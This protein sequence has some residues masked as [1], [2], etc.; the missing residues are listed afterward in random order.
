MNRGPKNGGKA[1]KKSSNKDPIPA[2]RRKKSPYEPELRGLGH[3]ISPLP[4]QGQAL[5]RNAAACPE[6]TALGSW[7]RG[8]S[9]AG[10]EDSALLHRP[11]CPRKPEE[12]GRDSEPQVLLQIL[13]LARDQEV[14]LSRLLSKDPVSTEDLEKVAQ[15]RAGLLGHYERVILSDVG[16]SE[17]QNVSQALWKNAFHQVIERLGQ[18]LRHPKT[19]NPEHMHERLLAVLDQGTAFFESL[20]EKL[21]KQYRFRL[22]DHTDGL[23]LCTKPSEDP[24]KYALTCAQKY[25]ICLGDIARYR[26]QTRGATNFAQAR[27]WYLKAQQI[28]P[29]DSRPYNQLALL[30]V[31]TKRKLEAVCYFMRSLAAASPSACSQKNLANLLGATERKAADRSRLAMGSSPGAGDLQRSFTRSFLQA[32]RQLFTGQ[33][34]T[35]PE[36]ADQVLQTFQLLLQQSPASVGNPQ[37]LRLVTINI[38]AAHSS[39]KTETSSESRC[40]SVQGEATGLGLAMFNV[41]VR[42]CT[43]WLEKCPRAPV[44][45]AEGEEKARQ[46]MVSSFSPAVKALL[47]SVKI[48]SEWMLISKAAW[49]P[50]PTTLKPYPEVSRDVRGTLE[51]L[52]QTLMTVNTSEV[53]LYMKPGNELILLTLEE[54]RLF[55]GFA[56]LLAAPRDPCYLKTN[57]DKVVAGNCR[58]VSLLKD[59][60]EA[61][62]RQRMNPWHPETGHARVVECRQRQTKES[63]ECRNAGPPEALAPA[64]DSVKKELQRQQQQRRLGLQEDWKEFT[65]LFVEGRGAP[66]CDIRELE[67][68]KLVLAKKIAEEEQRREKIEAILE[69]PAQDRQTEEEGSTE[70]HGDLAA[71]GCLSAWGWTESWAGVATGGYLLAGA[72]DL[73]FPFHPA[74]QKFIAEAHSSSRSP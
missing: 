16:F 27:S 23:G 10:G 55:S 30:A 46:I 62:C 72:H 69:A 7:R 20:L 52:C 21:Q 65:D 39:Q 5:P 17:V 24:L 66:G 43:Y 61:L 36:V 6:A 22:A 11:L 34:E 45:P 41:L 48:W 32:H 64:A 37:M 1:E 56:P 26:E 49:D 40:P 57:S 13:A 67:A 59:L 47:P 71:R 18:L 2:R 31:Y 3:R 51:L 38:F 53:P 25:M 50:T 42:C 8:W 12:R 28:D 19:M 29:S 60:L 15:C 74:S 68:K 9:S 63:L 70:V 54:D 33:L 14:Q 35:F 73:L 44:S 4:G 58:R